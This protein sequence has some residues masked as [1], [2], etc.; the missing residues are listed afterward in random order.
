MSRSHRRR[1][2]LWLCV[3][4][5]GATLSGCAVGPDYQRPPLATTDSYKELGDW[6]PSEPSDA[7]SRGP[8]WTI[9]QDDTLNDL[10]GRVNIS[11][12]NIKAAAASFEQAR[13]LVAQAKAGFWPTLSATFGRTRS[14]QPGSIP[15]VRTE[16][17]VGADAAWDL[18][19]WGSVRRTVESDRDSAEASAALL[20]DAQ[21]SAQ[22][23]LATDYFQLRAQ[24][25]LQQLL[26]DTV[27]AE[28][29]SLKIT[30]SRYKF[31]VAA[32]A[33]VVTAETQLLSS[34]A[35]QVNARVLR[36]TLEHAIAVLLGQSPSTFTL[37]RSA[38][39][40]DVPTVPPGVPSTLLE[41]RPD[42]ASAERK[43]AAANAQ[44][45]VATAAYFPSLTLNAT[46]TTTDNSLRQLFK[47]S[48]T[49]WSLGPQLAETIIDGGLRRAQVAQAKAAYQN[50]VA[51][52]RETVL[53]SF[54]QVEDEIVTLRVLEE[55]AVIEAKT[56][57]AA[58][59]AE[60]LTLN[61]YK[62]GTV[63][64]SSV[65][66]AQTARL[67]AEETELQV[68]SR[69]LQASVSLIEALGGG[70]DES[71]AVVK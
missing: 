13:A 65:I 69:R 43:M 9:Y 62:A 40:T 5:V 42:V 45:G 51:T 27:A 12:E 39:R 44:I 22:A 63:P 47:S 70:W 67:S 21:L 16:Y 48:T 1:C 71:Q 24:D 20:A 53:T 10:E 3:A 28:T 6:K 37:P 7:L 15:P 52:Y 38:I 60:A 18:D 11:N 23:A 58:R 34:Q 17:S 55:Q 46:G 57:K 68:L 54:Q 49:V 36:G 50:S 56:V 25:Q 8:W 19:V 64:Y 35:S 31:G 14:E 61:Q 4:T 26:D 30:E 29:R 41:R 33:D 32:R 2:A 66:T 59:E